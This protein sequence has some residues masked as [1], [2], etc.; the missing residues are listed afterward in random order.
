MLW[1]FLTKPISFSIEHHIGED[2]HNRI[3]LSVRET[4][5][6][7][8]TRHLILKLNFKSENAVLGRKFYNRPQVNSIGKISSHGEMIGSYFFLNIGHHVV[9]IAHFG[10]LV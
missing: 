8:D 4:S 1:S 7:E 6:K 10:E 9:D 2:L 5:L 3:A